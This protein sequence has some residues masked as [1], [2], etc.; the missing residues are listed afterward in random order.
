MVDIHSLK[1][2]RDRS[3]LDDAHLAFEEDVAFTDA[4]A[5]LWV[6]ALVALHILLGEL[7]EQ[8]VQ[9]INLMCTC[10]PPSTL[11]TGSA[12]AHG[13]VAHISILTRF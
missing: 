7:L 1:K 4:D 2:H 9:H 6:A 8:I 12:V 11:Q 13:V 10:T 5:S 3:R